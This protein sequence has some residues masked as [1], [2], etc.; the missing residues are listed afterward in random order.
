MQK[1]LDGVFGKPIGK[2]SSQKNRITFRQTIG[3]SSVK[4]SWKTSKIASGKIVW[5]AIMKNF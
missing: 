5:K 1:L 4:I 3:K 2:T